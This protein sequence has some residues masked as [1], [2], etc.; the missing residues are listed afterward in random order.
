V[1][2][3]KKEPDLDKLISPGNRIEIPPDEKTAIADAV[4]SGEAKP[5]VSMEEGKQMPLF[6]YG[7]N[8][9]W[10]GQVINFMGTITYLV[11]DNLIEGRGRLRFD[12]TGNKMAFELK[13]KKVMT[14]MAIESMK[15]E[16]RKVSADMEKTMK[17]RRIDEPF[18]LCFEAGEKM[19]SIMKKINDSNQFNITAIDKSVEESK[20]KLKEWYKT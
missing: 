9:E 16:I 2:R 5:I 17:C 19:E 8:Y 1:K 3:K 6:M 20:K 7:I 18:E 14:P 15:N 11:K 10:C 4:E 13:G 12:I